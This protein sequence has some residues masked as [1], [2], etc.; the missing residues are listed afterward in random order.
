MGDR[1]HLRDAATICDAV[2]DV[3]GHAVNALPPGGPHPY[4]SS[5]VGDSWCPGP[6]IDHRSRSDA[7]ASEPPKDLP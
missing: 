7:S 5:L 1:R 2:L 6:K 4:R 3:P